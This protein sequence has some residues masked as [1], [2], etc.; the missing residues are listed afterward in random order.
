MILFKKIK[1]KW[2][3]FTLNYKAIRFYD[4]SEDVIFIDLKNRTKVRTYLNLIIRLRQE[5]NKPI[6]FKFNPIFIF[7][8]SKWFSTFDNLF[9]ANPFKKHKIYWSFSHSKKSTFQ[10]SYSYNKVLNTDSFLPNVVPYIMH[11]VNY[12]SHN[13]SICE[14]KNVGI[15]FSG[16]VDKNIYD[17]NYIVDRFKIEN[18]YS[19]YKKIGSNKQYLDLIF[20]EFKDNVNTKKYLQNLIH[21]KHQ[22]GAIPIK[23]W[24]FYLSGSRFI[25][26]APGMTMPLCHNVL[27]AMSVGVVPIINYGNWLNPS[28][29]NN[30]NCLTFDT[31]QSLD[32]VINK[33]IAM[34]EKEYVHLQKNVIEY[35][36]K[37]YQSFSFKDKTNTQLILINESKS[38]L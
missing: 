14:E 10:V 11:P 13:A 33:A 3:E 38:D 8:M 24:L 25:L 36:Q 20:K 29:V 37:Y 23:D 28:L 16:N 2:L 18:R 5:T 15:L 22:S 4:A 21:M 31:L 1:K 12:L 34:P 32:T 9:I 26:C 6:V 27:E 17:N 30:E 19:I 35:Y 7:V